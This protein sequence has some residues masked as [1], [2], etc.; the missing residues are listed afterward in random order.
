[1]SSF[2]NDFY[3]PE[4]KPLLAH[5]SE[6]FEIIFK[7]LEEMNNE[8]YLIVETGTT[9]QKDNW[10]G[11]GQSTRLFDHFSKIHNGIVFSVDIN[12]DNCKN[13][14]EIL[15]DS[16]N[17]EIICCDSVKFLN[18]FPLKHAIDLLYLDSYDVD[19]LNI[20][21]SAFHHMKEIACVYSSL[22]KGCLI[23]IDDNMRGIGK[24][25][26]VTQFLNN[27]GAK[28]VHFGYITIFQL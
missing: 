1:M 27:I 6:C 15:Q 24:G 21:A 14:R 26:Y 3:I 9:R 13:A 5:R 4:Y 28:P 11:D 8:R 23:A 12:D 7:K 10:Q 16:K 20:H 2:L 25:S 17:T 19:W 18:E 22:K